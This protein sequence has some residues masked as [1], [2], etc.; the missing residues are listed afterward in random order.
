MRILLVIAVVIITGALGFS[1]F[2]NHQLESKVGVLQ[3]SINQLQSSSK[4]TQKT[5]KDTESSVNIVCGSISDCT[6]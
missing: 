1:I 2:Q 5:L 4:Q 6:L 3:S